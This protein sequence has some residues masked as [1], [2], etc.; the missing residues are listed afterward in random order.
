MLVGEAPGE[1]EVLKRAPFMGASGSTLDGML[2]EAGIMRSE[3]FITNVARERPPE[4]DISSW[5][6]KTKKEVTPEMVV[7]R[8]KYVRQVV[9]KGA[10]LLWQE[11]SM[12]KPN[13]IV[14]FGNVALW[15]LT[16]KWGI[17]SWRGSL[18]QADASNFVSLSTDLRSASPKVIPTYHPAYIMRDWSA[19][20]ITVQDLRRA[21][22]HIAVAGSVIRTH[23]DFVVRPI[24]PQ[25]MEFLN[26]VLA[27]LELEPTTISCDLETRGGHIACVGIS[28]DKV[29]ALCIPLMC[30]ERPTGYWNE[31]EEFG[32]LQLLQRVLT[33][34]NAR[35]VGQNFIYDTQY[36]IRHYGYA[37]RFERD[38]ML[39]HHSVFCL[40]PKGLDYISSMYCEDYVYWKDDGK[41]WDRKT[42]E[43]QLWTYNCTDCVR[44]YECDEVIQSNVDKLGLR[45]Q[46][47]FQQDMF[48]PV[49]QAMV[50]GVRVDIKRRST[51]ALELSDA[52]ADREQYFI[53]VLGHPLNPRSPK[54][55]R[56]LFYGDFQ[57]KEII[58]RKTGN[59]TLDDEALHKIAAREPLLRPLVKKISEYRSLGVFLS[60]FVGASLD[61]D[62]R[63]RC[64]YNIAGTGTYRLSSSTNAFDSGLNL[65]NIPEGGTEDDDPATLDLPNVK[66]LFVPDPGYTFFDG[67]LDRADL[68]VVVWEAND[69]DMKKALKAGIDMHL[70]SARAV[71]DLPISDEEMLESH[72]NYR[73][74]KAK[75]FRQR[76]NTRQVVHATNY[77][78][79]ARTVAAQFG[80]TVHEVDKFQSRWFQ[81]HPGIKLWHERIINQLKTKRYVENRF[82]YRAYYFDRL[83]S[84]VPEAVAWGP[85]STVAHYINMIWLEVY[86]QLP[87]VQVLLQVHDS[88]AGQIPTHLRDNQLAAISKIASTIVVPYDDPLVIPFRIKTSPISWGDCA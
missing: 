54:Q 60:T 85:Q 63:L 71:Y 26:E 74:T 87:E 67:D 35:V 3:C 68:Q 5:I 70:H 32:I 55:M 77:V 47:D 4:N 6:A 82:G 66:T 50:R 23:Y 10:E 25:V 42:G 83:D 52:L 51:F 29:R 2:H 30:V 14:A 58:S 79:S 27:K 57:Q 44:T 11:I 7:M 59:A 40:L 31:D 69:E 39:G 13:V 62:Q 15:A 17:K 41:T 20:A 33:H 72:P 88:L 80:L 76:Q 38:T 65:Q 86:R 9:L 46:H 45:A 19:R 49:L 81:I 8:D 61:S 43:D 53:D 75:Y 1:Q 73:E 16:G 21:R 24:F 48:W 12:V 34:P 64:S 22:G 78:G 18:L 28:L 36:F 37:P 56:E 84:I